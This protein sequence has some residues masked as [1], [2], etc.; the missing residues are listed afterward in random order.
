VGSISPLDTDP[1]ATASLLGRG[2][3]DHSPAFGDSDL[4][5]V[6]REAQRRG[7][8]G[9]ARIEDH[10]AHAW[11]FRDAAIGERLLHN[12]VLDLGSGGGLPGLV[13]ARGWPESE[14][15]LVEASERRCAFLRWGVAALGLEKRVHVANERAEVAARRPG[16]RSA[17]DL[18]V[19]RGFAKPAATA[20]CAVGFLTLGGCL[21]VAEPPTGVAA[22]TATR[23]S[24]WP[25]DGC[26]TLGLRPVPS[27]P[28][29]YHYQILQMVR[30][31]RDIY[32][33]R[34]GVPMRRPLF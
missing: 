26:E 21:V 8:L 23:A 4:V 19:S 32:P 34:S 22:G 6:L 3:L 25:A 28:Q 13:L 33:R 18:V 1:P 9:S 15:L 30:E 29:R 5:T 12:R 16:W 20:E 11:G 27:R 14:L 7:F 2:S 17:F 24:R 10:I 31:C